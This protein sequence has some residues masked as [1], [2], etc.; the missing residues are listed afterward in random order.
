M[1]ILSLL[2]IDKARSEYF[3]VLVNKIKTWPGEAQS[4]THSME[5]R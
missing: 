2:N 4:Y 3:I 5:T 1:Y